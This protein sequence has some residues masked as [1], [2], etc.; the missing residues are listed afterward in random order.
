MITASALPRLLACPSS[1]ALARAE[2]HSEW[3]DLGNEEH[4]DLSD[5]ANLPDDLKIYVPDGAR[6]EVKLSYDTL[7]DEGRVI[8]EGSGRDYGVVGPYAIVGSTDVIGQVDDAVVIVDWKTGYND[9]EP[10]STNGQ[11][12]YYALAAARALGLDRAIVRVVYT[13]KS[14]ANRLD[15]YELDA[16]ELA[17]FAARLRQLFVSTAERLK[18]KSSGAILETRE[19]SWC[20]YCPGKAHC[21]SKNALLVQI[22][23]KGLAASGDSHMTPARAA[24]AYREVM[25]VEQLVKDAKKRLETHVNEFGPID[26]GDGRMYGRYQRPGKESLDA[27]T[28]IVAIREVVGE[29][30]AEF[31]SIAVERKVSKAAIERAAKQ[32]VAKG[33]TKVATNVIKRVRELGGSKRGDE[34]PIGEYLADKYKGVS[35]DQGQL[36]DE[37]DKLLTEVA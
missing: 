24:D 23:S 29:Q 21:P 14:A 27:Q 37:A 12:H 18:Q 22:G 7:T 5:L 31:E 4:E 32:L 20:R 3:A 26:L 33:A 16:L 28:A 10:A 19:G 25:L 2:N 34:Y 11:L 36:A 13:K 6:S 15:E 9:V 30:A 17:G 8:G 35:V 1:F